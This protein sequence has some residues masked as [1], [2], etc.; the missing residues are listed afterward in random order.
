MKAIF[1]LF[2]ATCTLAQE[3]AHPAEFEHAGIIA[4][5]KGCADVLTLGKPQP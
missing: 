2:F 1:F 3:P 5:R 4:A